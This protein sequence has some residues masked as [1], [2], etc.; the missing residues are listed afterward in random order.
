M[1]RDT[2]QR[3]LI[4]RILHDTG[5]P[6]AP[7]EVLDLARREQAQ[8]G[9][10]T[11]YRNLNALLAEGWLA[12]VELPGEPPRYELSGKAHHHH[13]RCRACTGV[14]EIEGCAL[15]P[16]GEVPRGFKVESHEIVLYGLCAQ[17]A[18]KHP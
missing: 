3:R 11:I 15:H 7:R 4:R 14:F 18:R 8:M 12:P 13:F 10:A 9:L 1:Q 5:R 17:C 16:T 6:L 2:A